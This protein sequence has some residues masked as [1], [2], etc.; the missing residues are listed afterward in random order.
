MLITT[1]VFSQ[2]VSILAVDAQPFI[3][4][5]KNLLRYMPLNIFD[6]D[7]STVY[8]KNFDSFDK[9][10]PIIQIYLGNKIKINSIKIKNGY[11]DKLYYNKNYR[12]KSG[13]I[14]LFNKND[15]L[16]NK[17]LFNLE[18]NMIVQTIHLLKAY[19]VKK[20]EIY[21]E[22]LY[23]S[24]KWKDIVI[25]DLIFSLDTKDYSVVYGLKENAYNSYIESRKYGVTNKIQYKHEEFVKLFGF[26]Y[27]YVYDSKDRLISS[28]KSGG[29]GP[30]GSITVCEY[31][32]PD[33]KYPSIIYQYNDY[34]FDDEPEKIINPYI[35]DKSG[36][37]ISKQDF[38]GIYKYIYNDEQLSE[39]LIEKSNKIKKVYYQNKKC[40]ASDEG[41]W[42]YVF[43]YDRKGL[44]KYKI[45]VYTNNCEC[46][47]Y[48]YE[49]YENDL[50][51]QIKAWTYSY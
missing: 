35:L 22:S 2:E 33:N 5:E 49:Y 3:K 43:V 34:N 40:I 51:K 25:S 26:E 27:R 45:P 16:I 42:F 6:G 15:S 1:I 23:L 7:S 20:I 37:V 31:N 4:D 18:D 46:A 29:D 48:E 38:D 24:E 36:L 19:E 47:F 10:K 12:I 39:E 13:Y 14:S 11:F 21:V 30:G 17:Q 41:N 44:P 8:A 50:V 9:E 28:Y 32:S